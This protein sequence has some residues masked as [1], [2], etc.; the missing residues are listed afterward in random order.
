MRIRGVIK[1][2]DQRMLLQRGLDDTALHAAPA[3]MNQANL[4]EARFV[5]GV[6]VLFHN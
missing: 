4:T 6:Y 1:T 2:L 5:R 3:S